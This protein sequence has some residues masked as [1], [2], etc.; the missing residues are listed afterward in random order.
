[1]QPIAR[2]NPVTSAVDVVRALAE[3][4]SLAAPALHLAAWVAGLAIIPGA[5]AARRWQSS[6]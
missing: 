4:G 6:P 2:I 3:G 1:M 5:L